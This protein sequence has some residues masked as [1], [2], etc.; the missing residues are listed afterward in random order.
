MSLRQ[1]RVAFGSVAVWCD[2]AILLEARDPSEQNTLVQVTDYDT[3]DEP[4]RIADEHPNGTN[5]RRL[6]VVDNTISEESYLTYWT[7]KQFR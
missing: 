7:A 6:R 2:V 4:R 1:H 3:F 5:T